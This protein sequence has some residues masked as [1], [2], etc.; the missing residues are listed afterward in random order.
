VSKLHIYYLPRTNEVKQSYLSSVFTT[1][2]SLAK[3]FQLVVA[4]LINTTH[5]ISNG[6]GTCVPLFYTFFLLK[7]VKLSKAKLVFI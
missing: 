5:F 4:S 2:R 6:P 1:I 3:S 7:I